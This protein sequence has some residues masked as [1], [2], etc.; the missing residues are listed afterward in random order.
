MH[1]KGIPIMA[2]K[3][4][5]TR[6]QIPIFQPPFNIYS[7][8]SVYTAYINNYLLLCFLRQREL[9]WLLVSKSIPWFIH[10]LKG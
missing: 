2:E 10:M 7:L 3:N 1:M 9:L 4:H 8:L 6:L 5:I